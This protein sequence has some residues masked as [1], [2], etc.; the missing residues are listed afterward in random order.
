M[1]FQ[2]S[3]CGTHVHEGEA[4]AT[5]SHGKR[6]TKSAL[7]AAALGVTF[8]GASCDRIQDV[9]PGPQAAYGPPP[10]EDFDLS[11]PPPIGEDAGSAEPTPEGSGEPPPSEDEGSGASK[12]EATE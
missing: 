11:A 10:M 3:S 5:C 2:C 1:L 7:L 6:G 12:G 8:A 9:I 4:C